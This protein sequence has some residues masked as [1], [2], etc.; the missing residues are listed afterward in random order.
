MVQDVAHDCR[1]L[2]TEDRNLIDLYF[3]KH[4]KSNVCKM[5]IFFFLFTKFD[6]FSQ[7]T[8]VASFRFGLMFIFLMVFQTTLPCIHVS[9]GVNPGGWRS[10]PPDFGQRVVGV[11]GDR[12][13]HGRILKYYYTLSCAGSMFEN[14]CF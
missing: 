14:G 13:G 11:A 8:K 10:R 7:H 3:F 2:V 5:N 9:R 12:G 1:L 6:H 4:F